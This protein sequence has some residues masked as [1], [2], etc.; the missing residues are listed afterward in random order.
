M[1]FKI[2]SNALKSDQGISG[3]LFQVLFEH[4]HSSIYSCDP[5]YF[6]IFF[7]PKNWVR[8]YHC[9]QR[10]PSV[11]PL[12]RSVDVVVVWPLSNR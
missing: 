10:S 6:R 5:D 4:F 3:H 12:A 1:E 9:N 11:P 7:K 8:L 2:V